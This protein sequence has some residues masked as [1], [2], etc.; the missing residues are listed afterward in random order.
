MSLSG[1]DST[2]GNFYQNQYRGTQ[3]IQINPHIG[4]QANASSWAQLHPH[5]VILLR[6]ILN[7]PKNNGD[8]LR[9]KDGKYEWVNIRMIFRTYSQSL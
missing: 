4:A 5:E 3:G 1:I 9:W 8:V 6:Q 2:G 7:G